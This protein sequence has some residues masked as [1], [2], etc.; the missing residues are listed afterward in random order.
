MG[1]NPIGESSKDH[2][3]HLHSPATPITPVFVE[4]ESQASDRDLRRRI[5]TF[6]RVPRR[7]SR[8]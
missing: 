8:K 2:R 6:G 3:P 4:T 5:V 7:S 1:G